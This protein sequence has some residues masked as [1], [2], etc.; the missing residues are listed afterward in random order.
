MVPRMARSLIEL[1]KETL[2]RLGSSEDL[3]PDD[4]TLLE[5][6]SSIVRTIAE[7]EVGKLRRAG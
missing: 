1:L 3:M 5:L 7:L 2:E 4:P 6:K